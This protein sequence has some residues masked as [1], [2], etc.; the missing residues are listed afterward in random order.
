LFLEGI[1][2]KISER[3]IMMKKKFVGAGILLIFILSL[4]A[5]SGSDNGS[6]S[7][8]NSEGEE[9]SD[10][11]RTTLSMAGGAVGGSFYTLS[12]GFSKIIADETDL[13]TINVQET[14]GST[15]EALNL[16]LNDSV[17]VGVTDG[18][19]IF[20]MIGDEVDLSSLKILFAGHPNPVHWVVREDSDIQS[21]ADYVGKDIVVGNPNSGMNINNRNILE[22]G[23]GITFDDINYKEIHVTEGLDALINGN[24]DAINIPTGYPLA[25]Y[26]DASNTEDLRLLQM[27]EDEINN[28]VTEYPR[29]SEV[30]IPAKTYPGQ[31][32]DVHTVGSVT[33]YLARS[34][35]DDDLVYQ[36]VKSIMENPE[37][38]QNVHVL[39]HFY[40]PEQGVNYTDSLIE[41]GI[42]FHPGA[43]KYYEEKNVLSD[44]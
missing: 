12:T 6:T 44:N 13:L 32:E 17:D 22:A 26:L 41:E 7:A 5:C 28:V 31:D 38:L 18:G 40:S 3:G 42:E 29:Y 39:G 33:Y 24:A 23:W 4:A 1:T 25:A 27:T 20:E 30:V 11:S 10:A 16:L 8:S 37:E 9:S 21:P 36:F 34:D 2:E 15:T 19:G 35:L 14:P 43:L